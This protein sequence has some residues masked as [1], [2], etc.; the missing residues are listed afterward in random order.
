MPT[1]REPARGPHRPL[2]RGQQRQTRAFARTS[3]TPR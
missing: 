3:A 1:Y 2:R